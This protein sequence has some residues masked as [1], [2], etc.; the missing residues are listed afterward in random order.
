[1][2]DRCLDSYSSLVPRHVNLGVE[3][4]NVVDAPSG[5][6]KCRVQTYSEREKQ[7]RNLLPVS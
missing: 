7:K 4:G 5:C 1:M 2:S 3:G 6:R